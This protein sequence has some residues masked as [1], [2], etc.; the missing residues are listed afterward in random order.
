MVTVQIPSKPVR[1]CIRS[2]LILCVLLG[3]GDVFFA[4]GQIQISGVRSHKA[5]EDKFGRVEVFL[6]SSMDNARISISGTVDS[7]L[8]Q[9]SLSTEDARLL[10]KAPISGVFEIDVPQSGVGYILKQGDSWQQAY[11]LI[12][13]SAYPLPTA[14]LGIKASR[15]NPCEMVTV[16]WTEDLKSMSYHTP[17][18]LSK[19]LDRK[20]N[21]EY[22]NVEWDETDQSYKK[23][24]S[25]YQSAAVGYSAEVPSSLLDVAYT[26]I[27]D[28]W[29][30]S[31][32]VNYRP[33]STEVF[34]CQ[35]LDVHPIVEIVQTD[36]L[37]TTDD[38][39]GTMVSLSDASA[40]LHLR[41]SAIGNEPSASLFSWFIYRQGESRE[42]P[43]VRYLGREFDYTFTQAGSY[44]IGLEVSNRDQSCVYADFK[45][46]VTIRE[47]KLEIPNAFSPK[48]SVGVNDVFRVQ[49]R[50]LISFDAKV[51]DRN[52]LL[53]YQWQDPN[54]GWDGKHNGRYVSDGVYFYVINAK[55][56]DGH[57]YHERGHIN[58]LGYD[59]AEQSLQK[60]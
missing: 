26:L 8:W 5:A 43:I 44:T 3:R 32:G 9:Y 13:Y 37:H 15:N 12:D 22:E 28:N 4:V 56:A 59:G 50:S 20:L 31:L 24:K 23:V 29:G 10:Y 58:I 1:Q 60:Q 21:F 2:L 55:G 39:T 17:A 42:N 46:N 33:H 54:G 38:K 18:G 45:Q 35:R 34:S 51:Y 53:L 6:L 57:Q 14:P 7:E 47:S 30:T 48:A 52:G 11:W 41:L 16:T 25:T 19:Q 40:P 27:G 49:H 36:K